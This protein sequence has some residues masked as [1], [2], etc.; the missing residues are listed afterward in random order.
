MQAGQVASQLADS[1]VQ[2]EG[3]LFNFGSAAQRQ[4]Q[5]G[6][7]NKYQ[8][9]MGAQNQDYRNLDVLGGAISRAGGLGN[10]QT[11][12]QTGGNNPLAQ[13]AG[14]AGNAALM[15]SGAPPIMPSTG[16]GGG[17]GGG[18]FGSAVPPGLI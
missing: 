10:T 18:S 17:C 15:F 7:D 16:G 5:Q 14:L 4:D 1:Q 3:S 2:R 8:D 11:Q 9:F 12:T 13:I 6:L